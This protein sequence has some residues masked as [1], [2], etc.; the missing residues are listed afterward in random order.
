LGRGTYIHCHAEQNEANN[1]YDWI[2]VGVGV[3]GHCIELT[4]ETGED[5]DGHCAE[6]TE[7]MGDKDLNFQSVFI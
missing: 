5:I 2:V 3:E 6:L 1:C 4:E 7:K